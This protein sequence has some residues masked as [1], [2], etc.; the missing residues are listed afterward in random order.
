MMRLALIFLV[1]VAATLA[2][3]WVL[4]P[5]GSFGVKAS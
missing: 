4:P 2:A 3:F 1:A 5:F